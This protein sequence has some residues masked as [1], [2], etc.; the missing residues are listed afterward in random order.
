MKPEDLKDPKFYSS[1]VVIN[2]FGRVLL[3]KRKEDAIYTPPGGSAQDHETPEQAGLRELFEESGI[4]AEE[5]DLQTLPTITTRNGKNCHCFLLVSSAWN[6]NPTLDPDKEVEKWEWFDKD[7]LPAG[8]K[9]DVRRFESVRNALMKFHGVTKGGEGSGVDGHQTNKVHPNKHN[10]K[11]ANLVGKLGETNPFKQHWNKLEHGAILEGA[12]LRSGKPVYTDMSQATAH[13]YT[14]EEH[15]EAGNIHYDK[16]DRMN[17]QLHKVKELGKTPPPEMEKIIQFH[18]KKFK[19][20]FSAADHVT[21]IQKEVAE[22]LSAKKQA[23]SKAKKEMKKSVVMMGYNDA[24]EVDTAKYAVEHR[25]AEESEWAHKIYEMMKDYSY[26]DAPRTISIDAGLLHLVKVED[27]V[28]TGFVTLLNLVPDTD[29][30]M[31]DNAKVRMERMTIPTLVQFL[32]AKDY[33]KFK[34]AQPV[35]PPVVS[36][37]ETIV[38]NLT[39]K[40]ELPVDVPFI[41]ESAIDKKI[42]ML[43]LLEKLIN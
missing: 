40:L 25:M 9:R 7:N 43:K 35:Q 31:Q 39:E 13:G 24:L 32:M 33:I 19:Q 18:M 16:A 38:E 11:T 8:L 12:Q 28:Y 1:V 21:N 23:D 27:G 26:G 34:P 22:K 2:P 6:P 17:V 42:V 14:P 20:H 15:R 3:G 36:D 30:V 10:I 41:E 5:K 29:E 4:I 37:I